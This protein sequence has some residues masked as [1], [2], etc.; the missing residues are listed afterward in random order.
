MNKIVPIISHEGT[1]V[2]YSHRLD[3]KKNPG[4][5]IYYPMRDWRKVSIELSFIMSTGSGDIKIQQSMTDGGKGS[6]L[7]ATPQVIS[8]SA[9]DSVSLFDLNVSGAYL[10]VDMTSVILPSEGSIQVTVLGKR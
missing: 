8:V 5:I 10:V 6:E 7:S 9:G 3:L 4:R 1:S 2:L